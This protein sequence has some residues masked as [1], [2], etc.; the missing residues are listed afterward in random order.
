VGVQCAGR[1]VAAVPCGRDRWLEGFWDT[2]FF[3][4]RGDLLV[5]LDDLF[6]GAARDLAPDSVLIPIIGGADLLFEVS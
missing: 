5:G 6:V 2:E 4:A 3:A 1:F